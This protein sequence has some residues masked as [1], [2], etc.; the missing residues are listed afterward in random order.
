MRLKSQVDKNN[1]SFMY[2]IL[3][4]YTLVLGKLICLAQKIKL[5]PTLLPELI[6][7]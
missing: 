5:I 4:E 3:M 6:N 7:S 2:L 1:L